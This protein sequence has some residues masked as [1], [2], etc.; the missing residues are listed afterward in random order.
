[1]LELTL[2]ALVVTSGKKISSFLLLLHESTVT[3]MDETVVKAE[4]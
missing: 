2:E 3:Q 1:M 4:K